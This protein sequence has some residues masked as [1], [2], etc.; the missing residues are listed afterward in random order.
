MHLLGYALRRCSHE[1][2]LCRQTIKQTQTDRH[3]NRTDRQR[4]TQTDRRTDGQTDRQT[5]GETDK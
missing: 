4:D 5:D 1:N 3:R 2:I